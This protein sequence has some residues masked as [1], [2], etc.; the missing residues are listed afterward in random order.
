MSHK[1]AINSIETIL[2]DLHQRF[3]LVINARQMEHILIWPKR[4]VNDPNTKNVQ[5]QEQHREWPCWRP[6]VIRDALYFIN[7]SIYYL[8][9]NK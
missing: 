4:N 3:T 9:V 8:G 5:E 6:Q 7:F 1:H 2:N